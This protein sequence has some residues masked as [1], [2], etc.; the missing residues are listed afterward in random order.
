MKTHK[1]D[2]AIYSSVFIFDVT[3]VFSYSFSLFK[4]NMHNYKAFSHTS[5]I[6]ILSF[7]KY[8]QVNFDLLVLPQNTIKALLISRLL[9]FAD[10]YSDINHCQTEKHIYGENKICIEENEK[11]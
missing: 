5:S 2:E 9:L 10:N 3:I 4:L 1:R 11:V 7:R 6:H 8:V